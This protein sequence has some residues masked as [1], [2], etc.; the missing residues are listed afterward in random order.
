MMSTRDAPNVGL[1]E[2]RRGFQRDVS[3][4]SSSSNSSPPP[5]ASPLALIASISVIAFQYLWP[6]NNWGVRAKSILTFASLILSKLCALASPLFLGRAADNLNSKNLLP[7]CLAVT[8]FAA[9]RIGAAIFEEANRVAFLHTQEAASCEFARTTFSHILRLDSQF[10]ASKRTPMIVRSLE[11]GI[12]AAGTTIDVVLVRL[13]PSVLEFFSLLLIFGALFGS[14]SSSGVL[15]GGFAIF[16]IVTYSLTFRRRAARSKLRAA[17]HSAASIALEVLANSDTVKAFC[18]ESV[19][20]ARYA[21]SF[22]AAQHATREAQVVQSA[23]S[24]L[25]TV[26]GR[27]TITGVLLVSALDVVN[28]RITIG[29]W[30]AIQSYCTALFLQLTRL[31]GWF[32]QLHAALNDMQS[33]AALRQHAAESSI[34]SDSSTRPLLIRNKEE[35]LEVQFSGV[36]FVYP[37]A[38]AASSGGSAAVVSSASATVIAPLHSRT[39][40]LQSLN[41]AATRAWRRLQGHAPLVESASTKDDSVFVVSVDASAV[42]PSP[43]QLPKGAPSSEEG[44]ASEAAPSATAPAAAPAADTANAVE[45][46]PA[47]PLLRNLT[48]T[49]RPG[50]TVAIVG[51]SGVGKSTIAKLLMSLWKTSGGAILLD[52]Q[53]ISELQLTSLR[54]AISLVP[55][56]CALFN[57]TIFYNVAYGRPDA[58]PADVS[59]ALRLAQLSDFVSRLPL[60]LDTVVGERGVKLSGGE[61]Q[62]VAIARAIL[63]VDSPLVIL[64]EATSALDSVTETAVQAALTEFRRRQ[65]TVIV[66]THRLSTIVNAHDIL[67]LQD[68]AIVEHGT[69]EELMMSAHGAYAAMYSTAA[70]STAASS[71]ANVVESGGSSSSSSSG[72]GVESEAYQRRRAAKIA[73]YR[74]SLG[75][76]GNV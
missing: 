67:V 28:G 61:R 15:L 56:D 1:G 66:I 17:D 47:P 35:G 7:A 52:G 30:V 36:Y 20:V 26:I 13:L 16:V 33:L 11:R 42:S 12:A 53:P 48:F 58:T 50:S 9:F 63:R 5:P 73:A 60:G 57:E 54:S 19:E 43:L 70:D 40:Y 27:V 45:L 68:G 74:A 62:R 8:A 34:D 18:A 38:T 32:L 76:G 51:R 24:V 25:Q 64:D 23:S 4:S 6:R 49:V 31:S 29:S 71:S 46:G 69:H 10:H 55:Q 37:T 75:Q 14:P 3:S 21:K 22:S 59:E 2:S 72:H 39:S 41:A 65:R 44:A